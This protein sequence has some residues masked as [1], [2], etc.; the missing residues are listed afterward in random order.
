MRVGG[1]RVEA[2]GKEG[3]VDETP[4][5]VDDEVLAEIV[6]RIVDVAAPER[7]VLFGSAAR[8]EMGPHSD[9]D[10]LIVK[11][12]DYHRGEL[13]DALYKHMWGVGGAVDLV[14]VKPE[15]VERYRDVHA[16]VIAPA[17]REG[18]VVY[19]A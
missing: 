9:Y 1:G 13:T 6:R 14:V 12:G 7:I 2:A 10:L 11:A 15:D 16:L 4:L 8:G 19:A 3:P 17:L 18:R 5:G